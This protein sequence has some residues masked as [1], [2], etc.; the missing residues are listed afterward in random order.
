MQLRNFVHANKTRSLRW[1]SG[2]LQ[3]KFGWTAGSKC[4]AKTLN[5]VMPKVRQRKVCPLN[6]K[7]QKKRYEFVRTQLAHHSKHPR[8]IA[9]DEM[10]VRVGD[11]DKL[12]FIRCY[13]SEKNKEGFM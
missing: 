3:E 4:L 1:F 12:T 11:N 5:K 10:Y 8:F 9:T 2:H 6:K 13:P 7:N